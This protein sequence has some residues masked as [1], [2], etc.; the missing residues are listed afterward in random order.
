[1]YIVYGMV[2]LTRLYVYLVHV[3]TYMYLC[4]NLNNFRQEPQL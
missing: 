3:G 4:M 2:W 1:M